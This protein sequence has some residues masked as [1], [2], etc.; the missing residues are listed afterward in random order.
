MQIL[1]I[2]L[3]GEIY[4]ALANIEIPSIEL[5]IESIR[6]IYPSTENIHTLYGR[7]TQIIKKPDE[8][9]L[10][11][12][13]K[14]RQMGTK[15]NELKAL[16]PNIIP[17]NLALFKTQLEAD[18]LS[19]FKRGLKQEIRLELGEHNSAHTAIQKAIEIESNLAKQNMLRSDTANILF[20]FE[21]SNSD[22]ARI[23]QCQICRDRNHEALFCFNAS[24]V[25]CKNR[26]HAS[27]YCSTAKN[28]LELICKY[29]NAKGH[30]IDKC[31]LNYMQG[32]HCQYCREMGHTVTQCPTITKYEL[33][34][35][36]KK[37]VIVRICAKRVQTS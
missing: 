13:N 9:V 25:Y 20:N 15:I 18:I 21:K 7:L 11:Y 17:E 30:S 24:C 31:Q 19:S 6:K 29:C 32:S 37:K 28:K 4:E 5:F 35:K 8:M 1:K 3:K 26:D 22:V 16:E 34:W 2:K 36:C 10:E 27:Y 12:A 14:I 33:C 23:S